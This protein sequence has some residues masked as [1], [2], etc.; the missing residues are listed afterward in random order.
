MRNKFLNELFDLEGA[1]DWESRVFSEQGD[2]LIK[3][4]KTM[5]I[6]KETR[7]QQALFG[8]MLMS[9]DNSK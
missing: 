3:E 9:L 6:F 2:L 1:F 5:D 4:G 8:E 7:D